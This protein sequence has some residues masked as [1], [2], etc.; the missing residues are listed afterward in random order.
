MSSKRVTAR[1]WGGDDRASWAV[2][3]D[4]RPV[5]TGLYRS[6]VDYYRRQAEARLATR[7][8]ERDETEAEKRE[9]WGK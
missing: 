9:S 2:L 1:K 5:M 8:S 6:E 7:E 4:G 3:V